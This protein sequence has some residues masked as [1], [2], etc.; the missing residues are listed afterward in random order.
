MPLSLPYALRVE[1][2]DARRV[3]CDV[4]VGPGARVR[5]ALDDAHA[6][7]AEL[8]PRLRLAWRKIESPTGLLAV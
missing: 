1:V 3:V 5:R 4:L 7:P 8:K 6:R 2:C